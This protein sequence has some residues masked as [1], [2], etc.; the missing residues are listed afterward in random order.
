MT[1]VNAG[2]APLSS[3]LEHLSKAVFMAGM[4]ASTVE[5]KWLGTRDAFEGFQ[6]ERVAALAAGDIERLA[7]DARI[8]RNRRKIEAIVTNAS[9]SWSSMPARARSQSAS[10]V[11]VRVRNRSLSLRASPS[12]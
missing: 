7:L 3:Y 2:M 8:V 10:P 6:P 9:R 12:S 5:A 1:A 4:S 11:S